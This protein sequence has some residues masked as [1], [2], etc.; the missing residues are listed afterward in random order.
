MNS[1]C[2][3][4]DIFGKPN[5]GLHKYRIFGM[6]AIDLALT[7]LLAY[8]IARSGGW[9]FFIV[10]TILMILSVIFHKMFCVKT[11]LT[12]KFHF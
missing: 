8:F 9:N 10:L 12:N 7:L 11:T 3:Y 4:Q 5:E 1:L 2:Q 6:A